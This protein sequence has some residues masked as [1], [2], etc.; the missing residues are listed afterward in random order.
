[1]SQHPT[2]DQVPFGKVF[3]KL[4]ARQQKLAKENN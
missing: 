2:R 3:K 1:M 4:N